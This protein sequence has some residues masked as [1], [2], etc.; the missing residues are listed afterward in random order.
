[1]AIKFCLSLCNGIEMFRLM[2][3]MIGLVLFFFLLTDGPGDSGYQLKRMDEK[4]KLKR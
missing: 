1:M 3:M 4:V 2:E